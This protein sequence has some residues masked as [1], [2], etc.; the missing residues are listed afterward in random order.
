MITIKKF[1]SMCGCNTQ[2]LRY[3]DKI[4]LLK[5]VQVDQW[6]GYRY[7][8]KSQAV[9]YV[10]IKNLQAAD[11]SIEEIK[12][13]VSMSDQ[14]VQEAFDQKIVQ[15]T[16]KLERIKEIKQSYLSEKN[17]MEQLVQNLS[18]YLL[19]AVSDYEILQE[20]G[21]SPE[22]GEQIVKKLKEYI[23]RKTLQH[24]PA[25]PD[26]QLVL[27]GKIFLGVDQVAEVLSS[28]KERGYEDDET[29]LLG[30]DSIQDDDGLTFQ[31]GETVWEF[32]GW[33]YVHEFLNQIPCL[34]SEFEYCFFFELTE[35]KKTAIITDGLEFPMFMIA[36][37]LVQQE[38]GDTVMGCC[39]KDSSDGENHFRL[40][41]KK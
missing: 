27:E 28:L 20:F 15:Q 4:G 24:L 37:M 38:Y 11:F 12:S 22:E 3:Y 18:A 35:E 8:E 14:Q 30:S 29:L 5:P 41:R 40:L 25:E 19:S 23:E 34:S 31:N 2:T 32:H 17:N 9:D 6:S 10:K 26:V 36:A 33:N 1:A 21:L 39:V 7:Y 16:Q 13:L